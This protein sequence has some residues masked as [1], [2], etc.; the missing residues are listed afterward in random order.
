MEGLSRQIEDHI[1][2][3]NQ[4]GQ[5]WHAAQVVNDIRS[6]SSIPATFC[7]LPRR[8]GGAD[9]TQPPVINTLRPVHSASS[10]A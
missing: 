8:Q 1:P 7:G 10:P 6:L 5:A 9:E 2:A 3:L 4:G